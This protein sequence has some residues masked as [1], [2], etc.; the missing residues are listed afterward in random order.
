MNVKIGVLSYQGSVAEHMKMLRKIPGVIAA[1]VKTKEALGGVDGIILPGGESTTI[2]KLLEIFG[3]S[4]PLRSRIK[5]GMP[6]YGTCAGLILLAK[7]V[8]NQQSYLNLMDIKVT[9]NAYGRQ[10]DS[11]ASSAIIPEISANPIETVFIRAPWI[12]SVYGSAKTLCVLDGHIVAARQDNM[13][14]TSFHPE[15]TNNKSVHE[16]F[17]KMVRDYVGG[18]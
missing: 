10:I 6:V 4:D 12:D 1:E 16:Y 14:V 3:L 18:K 7:Q 11:F 8:E 13:L 2:A 5:E 17:V 15:L 9:R